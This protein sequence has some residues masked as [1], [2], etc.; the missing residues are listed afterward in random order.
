MKKRIICQ[1]SQN[2]SAFIVTNQSSSALNVMPY[3]IK[4]LKDSFK[5]WSYKYSV[6]LEY[7]ALDTK[8][9]IFH[10]FQNKFH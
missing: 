4:P 1:E 8:N 7:R 6:C 2:I 9:I 10:L 5:K 3:Y